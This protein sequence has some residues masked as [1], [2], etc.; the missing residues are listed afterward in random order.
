MNSLINIR[1]FSLLLFSFIALLFTCYS[2]LV[3]AEQNKSS[4]NAGLNVKIDA[5]QDVKGKLSDHLSRGFLAL[6]DVNLVEE[7]PDWQL[8]IVAEKTGNIKKDKNKIV[9]SLLITKPFD[10]K[11]FSSLIKEKYRDIFYTS[12]DKLYE[13]KTQTIYT[14]Q[15][16]DLPQICEKIVSEFNTKYIQPERAEY[17]I[18]N[19]NM[20]K[21]GY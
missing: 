4:F 14:G 6:G 5:D 1:F 15:I 7:N 18:T 17:E 13:L 12:A 16:E 19:Q 21:L 9:I 10:K 11:L 3:R 8:F 20:K 2:G